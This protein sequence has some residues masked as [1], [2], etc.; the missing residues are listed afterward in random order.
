MVKVKFF[1]FDITYKVIDD[2]PVVH[3]FGR[4]DKGNQIIVLDENFKPYFY[5]ALKK[6]K[7][8]ANF[9][10]KIEKFEKEGVKIV[11]ADFI[12][13]NFMDKGIEL[14]KVI[15]KLPQDIAVIKDELRKEP[16]IDCFYETD[17]PFVRRYLIDKGII[18][19]N[20]ME[21]EGE[22]INY[23]AKVSVLKA[24]K[25]GQ[26]SDEITENPKILAFDIETYSPAGKQILPKENPILMIAFS[27]D[28]FKK[29]ITWKKFKTDIKNIEFV[30]SEAEL[31]NRFKEV[32]EDY[33]PDILTGYFSDGFDFPYIKVR[34]EEHKI[35]LDLGLDYSEVVIGRKKDKAIITGIVHLDIFKFIRKV[36]GGTMD[37][38]T[39]SLDAVSEELLDERKHNIDIES[40]SEAWDKKPEELE[41]FCKY[42]LQDAVLTFKL[43]KKLYPNVVELV[44]IV[45][46]PVN[47]VNRAGFS[48]LVEGYIMR[49]TPLFDEIIPSKPHYDGMSERLKETYKGA[50]V[51]EPIPGLYKNIVVFDFRSLYPTII[52]SHNISPATLNC[53]CCRE[54]AKYAPTGD[55]KY[56]FCSKKKGFIPTVI[57]NLITRRMRI[58]EII[59]KNEEQDP[60][61][62]ARQNSLKLLANSF[63]GYLAFFGARW[64]CIECARSVTA[65]GRF[66]IQKVIKDAQDKNFKVIYSD[67]D[68]ILLTLDGKTRDEALKFVETV[69]MELPG[70]MELEFEG[71]YPSGLF[72]SAKA[73]PYG[74]KKKYALVSSEGI[75]KITGFETVRRNWSFIAKETQKRVL[76]I[77]LKENNKEKALKYVKDVIGKLRNNEIPL[78]KVV[79]H[80]QLQKEI[81]NYDSVGPHVKVAMRMKQQGIPVGPG[82]LIKFV[83]TRGKESIGERARLPQEVSQEDYDPSYYID[84]QVVPSVERIFEV[85]GY[86]KG[87]LMEEK[88]QSKL[89]EFIK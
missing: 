71:F 44:R 80:T 8:P 40:L 86:K 65:W 17:I 62:D 69:N 22:Y 20:A 5:I 79:I 7:N 41:E 14:I 87:D 51:F 19:I 1:P 84:N 38:G 83:I 66:Y 89:G 72:V 45:G 60:L 31:I 29:V 59:K 21:I 37:T 54:N 39:Y 6:G 82:S 75:L 64:Y 18:P 26:I 9:I 76:E 36:F 3:L 27:G 42:N 85:L 23:K 4:T 68:S 63:Y 11:R 33:K 24:E 49:Q 48:Q 10:E 70:L 13:K 56:W 67:T 78:E 53:K 30:E 2:K 74:A 28:N 34:A 81:E 61:L 32:V 55:K 52:S 12:N 43:C 47:D 50:F 57:E 58:K 16:E 25:V 88:T 15:T 35:N 73:G 46:L 77:I